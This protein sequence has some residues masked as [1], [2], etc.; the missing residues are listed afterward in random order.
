MSDRC[1]LSVCFHKS[2]LAVVRETLGFSDTAD[3]DDLGSGVMRL[4]EED[5]S[6]GVEDLAEKIVPFEGWHSGTY[7]YSAGIFAS[8]NGVLQRADTLDDFYDPGDY[9]P[10]VPME[11]DGTIDER[12][13]L[14]AKT[15]FKRLRAVR[16]S[17]ALCEDEVP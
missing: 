15:Y 5:M 12:A 10:Y 1:W 17:F 2:D 16:R 9:R 3:L 4:Q 6:P 13:L 11:P 14:G 8:T 7:D